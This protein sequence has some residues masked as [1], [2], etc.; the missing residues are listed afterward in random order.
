[1]KEEE[2]RAL[3][4]RFFE[5]NETITTQQLKEWKV[6]PALI[7]IWMK[8]GI[9]ERVERGV[10]KQVQKEK[11]SYIKQEEKRISLSQYFKDNETI[12]TQQ[13]NHLKISTLL[14]QKWVEEGVLIRVKRGIYQEKKETKED[15]LSTVFTFQDFENFL[16]KNQ[17][18]QALSILPVMEEV[19]QKEQA[20]YYLDLVLLNQI[21]EFPH[22]QQAEIRK[23]KFKD[24]CCPGASN[25]I[26]NKIRRSIEYNRMSVAYRQLKEKYALQEEEKFSVKDQ[27]LA[28]L[29]DAVLRCEKI[30]FQL[31]Y[32]LEE[33]KEY[34]T[35]KNFLEQ[36]ERKR[37]LSQQENT[38]LILVRILLSGKDTQIKMKRDTKSTTVFEAIANHDYELARKLNKEYHEQN[39]N[40]TNL[41]EL[42]LRE[43]VIVSK[44]QSEKLAL[45]Q[46]KID[47]SFI[48]L[49]L[50]Q[51]KKQKALK[52][53]EV[54]LQQKKQEKLFPIAKSLVEL[55]QLDGDA[56]YQKPYQFLMEVEQGT[57]RYQL[58][59]YVL[60]FCE[61]VGKNQAKAKEYLNLIQQGEN[62][63][64]PCLLFPQLEAQFQKSQDEKKPLQKKKVS[65]E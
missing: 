23:L 34:E 48:F 2:K 32:A 8:K 43:I 63:N 50:L 64:A 49:Q 25:S 20:D 4:N 39:R 22:E 41:L 46:A 17:F 7:Q 29:L 45:E 51:G 18:N 52:D 59:P 19:P 58:F 28:Q 44:R 56:L 33:K 12:T 38:A 1:M 13:L 42:L 9:L 40:S 54:Y 16:L 21:V 60:S 36:K 37:E 6:S 57:Y 61:E 27:I 5:E 53:L 10:Y 26:D 3:M 15:R 30:D 35:L 31:E 62:L 55:S 47:S 65:K 14:I 24:F 11:R